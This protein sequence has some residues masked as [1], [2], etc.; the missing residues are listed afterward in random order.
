MNNPFF[1]SG[2]GGGSSS[3]LEIDGSATLLILAA[4]NIASTKMATITN[5]GQAAAD[6]N[7][8]L[9]TPV[10]NLSALCTVATAQAG[11]YWRFTA[12]G[13]IYLNG[14]ATAKN[15]VQ[16]S[17]PAVGDYFSF[18][19]AKIADGSYVYRVTSGIGSLT[20]N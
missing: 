19:T 20:T 10:A 15:Y 12:T 1:L 4:A 17:A 18:F 7:I 9:P 11:N 14:S 3:A 8:P 5:Y 6:V 16:L 2:G 13:K